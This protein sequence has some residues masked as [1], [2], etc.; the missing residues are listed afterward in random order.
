[1]TGQEVRD[2]LFARLFGLTAVIRSGLL[3][4]VTPLPTSASFET[5]AS[6]LAGYQETISQLIALGEKKSWLREGAWWT[7]MLAIEALHTSAV[8]WKNDAIETTIET[9]FVENKDWSPE[10]VALT[11]KL[12]GL[13]PTRDWKKYL[14]PSFKNPDFLSNT[15]LVTLARILKVCYVA[16]F[17]N[18]H[19]ENILG[20][21]LGQ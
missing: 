20:V 13:Y 7:I 11:V 10:K 2:M 18:L 5:L 1:M 6:S 3:I 9:L 4:R 15:N 17:H 19:T 14:S 12:Q 16:F 21:E 8:P